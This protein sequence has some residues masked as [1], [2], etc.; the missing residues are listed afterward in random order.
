[1]PQVKNLVNGFV[2]ES[3]FGGWNNL[4]KQYYTV[5]Q[6]ER[7]E[8]IQQLRKV[9]RMGIPVTVIDYAPPDDLAMARKIAAKINALGFHAWVSNGSLS[10]V[11][12][13]K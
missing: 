6:E 4:T 7:S 2:A 10:A 9:Q 5:N 1:L 8:L 12:F 13:Y 3:L 11:Y